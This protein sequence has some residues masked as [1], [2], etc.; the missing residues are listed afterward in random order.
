MTVVPSCAVTATVMTLDP[1]ESGMAL[2]AVTSRVH[3][4][5]AGGDHPV[6]PVQYPI[7]GLNGL[8]R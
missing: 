7:S 8:R 6:Q 1:R 2:L 4:A 5:A 3:V